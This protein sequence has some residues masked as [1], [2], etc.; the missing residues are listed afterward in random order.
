MAKAAQRR[1]ALHGWRPKK[2]SPSAGGPRFQFAV[3]Y[4][5]EGL[6]GQAGGGLGL[7]G[8]R[9]FD[10]A[11]HLRPALIIWMGFEKFLPGSDGS[12]APSICYCTAVVS[13]GYR[14]LDRASISTTVPNG[15]VAE[16]GE[17]T[18]KVKSQVPAVKVQPAGTTPMPLASIA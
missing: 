5:P 18:T 14:L 2:H 7:L 12:R 16:G 6:L 11:Q 13:A 1:F 17:I 4:T 10:E 15:E 8:P 9:F 3:R